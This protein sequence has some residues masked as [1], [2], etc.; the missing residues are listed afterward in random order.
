MKA[1]Y[2][3]VTVFIF[4]LVVDRLIEGVNEAKALLLSSGN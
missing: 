4:F 1:L 2:T 3:L